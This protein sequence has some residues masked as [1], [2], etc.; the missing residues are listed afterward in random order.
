[1]IKISKYFTLLA[2]FF[3][4]TNCLDKNTPKVDVSAID[5]TIDVHRFEQKFYTIS[6]NKLGVLKAEYPYLFPSSNTDSVWLSKMQ[7]KDEQL[8]FTESQKLYNNFSKET[9]QLESLFKHIKYY[10]PK[11][12]SP[13]V[14]TILT[15]VDYDNNVVVTDEFLFISLDIFLGKDNEIYQNFPEYIKQNYTKKHLIVAVAEKF[16]EKKVTPIFNQTYLYNMIQEGKKLALSQAFLPSV[17]ASE[18]IG[19][20]YEQFLWA[21][22]SEAEIWK[23]FIQNKM[24]YSTDPKLKN[25]FIEDAPFSKFFLEI[26]RDSPG[27]IGAWFGWQIVNAYIKNNKTSLQ[28]VILTENDEIFKNSKYKPRKN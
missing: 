14:I 15:N 5:V 28:Q 13:K 6:P 12:K 7:N 19:Y 27:K 1:M 24:L 25:R 2:L 20:T 17:S 18:I 9:I 16:V 8:L 10:Y 26:D 4:F 21:A 11:F 23:Y 22:Q 3:V